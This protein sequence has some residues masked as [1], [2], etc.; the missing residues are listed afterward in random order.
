MKSFRQKRE[1]NPISI[2]LVVPDKF[3]LELRSS[4]KIVLETSTPKEAKSYGTRIKEFLKD[5]GPPITGLASLIVVILVSYFGY[6]INSRQTQI[7][8]EQSDTARLNLRIA[9]IKEFSERIA[10]VGAKEDN[11]TKNLEAIKLAQYGED[12]LPTIKIA[13]GSD[14]D[15]VQDSIALVVA[16]LFQSNDAMRRKVLEELQAYFKTPDIILQTSVLNCFRVLDRRLTDE[17]VREITKL[18]RA[19]VN[20][21]LD[22]SRQENEKLIDQA[23]AFLSRSPSTDA[24]EFLLEV[25][26]NPTNEIVRFTAVNLLPGIARVLAQEERDD[27]VGRLGQLKKSGSADFD[28][29]LDDAITEVVKLHS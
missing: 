28:A 26:A 4:D 19:K 1:A 10:R 29:A 5:L 27:I 13:L 25:A 16:Y 23:I 15:R 18:I 12:A 24:K 14:D 20:P 2:N 11:L 8:K 6:Q 7:Q 17:E 3:V 21:G 9:V 22:C